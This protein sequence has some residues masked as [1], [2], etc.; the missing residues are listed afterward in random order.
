MLNLEDILKKL[1]DQ[2][3]RAIQCGYDKGADPK[4]LKF[5]EAKL[6]PYIRFGNSMFLPALSLD[7]D[8]HKD[9]HLVLEICYKNKI[10]YPTLIVET[11]KGLHIHW[12]L[13]NPINLS[14]IKSKYFYQQVISALVTTF[15]TDLNA[16]PKNSGRLFRNPLMHQTKIYNNSLMDLGAFSDLAKA[17]K[18]IYKAQ[19]KQK[20]DSKF[21]HYKRPD[22]SKVLEGGRNEALFNYGRAYA[23]R[24]AKSKTL[25]ENLYTRLSK[26][27]ASLRVPIPHAELSSIV[28]SVIQFIQTKYTAKTTN[29]RTI[30]FN[31]KLA[32]KSY[33]NTSL[34][35][36]DTFFSLAFLTLKD[37]ETM[38]LRMGGEIFGVHKNTYKKH[39]EQLINDIKVTAAEALIGSWALEPT[40]KEPFLPLRNFNY[41]SV[42]ANST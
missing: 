42:Y 6:T 36:L 39:L 15:S 25:K 26:A 5:A 41:T 4:F 12:L 27:N 37:L 9:S 34:K 8:N 17:H 16:V 22:F 20:R 21:S 28:T 29:K 2:T 31:K 38:S 10:P 3:G 32:K 23:Y 33:D 14:N 40:F 30:E 7:I 13:T 19:P 24:F 35:L 11:D 1:T 18:I